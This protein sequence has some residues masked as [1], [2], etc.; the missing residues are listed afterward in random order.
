MNSD[1]G[2]P[3]AKKARAATAENEFHLHEEGR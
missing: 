2:P 1:D 3:S